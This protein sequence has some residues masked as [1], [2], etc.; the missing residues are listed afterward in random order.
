MKVF[1]I[2]SNVDTFEDWLGFRSKKE[3]AVLWKVL[4]GGNQVGEKQSENDHFHKTIYLYTMFHDKCPFDIL[5]LP[6]KGQ[7][8]Q[9]FETNH[10]FDNET[11]YNY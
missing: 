4:L 6:K 1:I 11:S 9:L 3:K 8:V 10:I 5:L 7:L 2:D